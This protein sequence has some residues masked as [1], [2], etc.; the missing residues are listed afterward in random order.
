MLESAIYDYLLLHNAKHKPFV[1]NKTAD[2]IPT[3]ERGALDALEAIR[4]NM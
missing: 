3:R 1:W 4:R 2:D